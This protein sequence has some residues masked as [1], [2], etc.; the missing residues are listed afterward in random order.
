M[1]FCSLQ[2]SVLCVGIFTIRSMRLRHVE[3]VFAMKESKTCSTP[4]QRERI[5]R[6]PRTNV[7]AYNGIA[8][9]ILPCSQ[10][11]AEVR[12][13]ESERVNWVLSY[14]KYG[15]SVSGNRMMYFSMCFLLDRIGSDRMAV[16]HSER[17]EQILKLKKKIPIDSQ[18]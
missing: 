18:L 8:Y 6:A 15:N 14:G 11:A 12:E 16:K 10:I 9:V 17:E 13:R 3:D 4:K 2:S 5:K 1:F 7:Y